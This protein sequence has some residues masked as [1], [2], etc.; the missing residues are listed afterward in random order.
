[1]AQRLFEYN[2]GFEFDP[3]LPIENEPM[4]KSYNPNN[5][6]SSQTIEK[7]YNYN[8]LTYK[9]PST[10]Y[11]DDWN[12]LPD[13]LSENFKPSQQL[14]SKDKKEKII[15]FEKMTE[16]ENNECNCDNCKYMKYI[17]YIIVIVFIFILI[18]AYLHSKQTDIL[19]E[20]I[21]ILKSKNT[22]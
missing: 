11:F 16:P 8:P 20:L 17:I 5:F 2:N 15:K 14:K 12:Y 21:E 6:D 22:Q 9:T 1:M 7:I 18:F 3:Y 13:K 19:K 10:S 4:G